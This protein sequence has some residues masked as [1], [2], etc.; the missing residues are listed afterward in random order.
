MFK[1]LNGN[2]Q[3]EAEVP[4]VG[5]PIPVSQLD[6][7]YVYSPIPRPMLRLIAKRSSA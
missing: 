6:A 3:E 2:H 4:L 1:L 5:H 7:E